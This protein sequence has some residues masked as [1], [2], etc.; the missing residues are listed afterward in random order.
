MCEFSNNRSQ[1]VRL[2]CSSGHQ[3]ERCDFVRLFRRQRGC[4]KTNYK[5]P[6]LG[7]CEARNILREF[8]AAAG[9]CDVVGVRSLSFKCHVFSD[10]DQ[11]F[12]LVCVENVL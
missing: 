8:K 12:E 6:T 2:D 5:M 11:L 10:A 9:L 3:V 4:D 1:L 7:V